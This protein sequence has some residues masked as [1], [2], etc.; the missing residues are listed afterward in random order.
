MAAVSSASGLLSLLSEPSDTLRS[1]ALQN[2]DRVVHE[3]WFQISASIASVEALYEDEEFGQRELAA[4]VASKVFYHLGELDD[5]LAYA[6]G[7]GKLFDVNEQSEYVQTL[8]ARCLD[9]Y[10]ELRLKQVEAKQDVQI[11]PRL[12]SIVERMLERCCVHGQ[13]EQAVGVALEARRLDKLEEIIQ[14]STDGLRTL[15]YALRCCQGLIINRDF[16]QQVLRLLI[17]LYEASRSPDYVDICQCLMFLDDAPEV[18]KILHSLLTGTEDDE[19]LA[20]QTC[21]DL[22]ENEMQSF[23][24][25]VGQKCRQNL[26]QTQGSPAAPA[27]EEG[28][29]AAAMDTDAPAPAS[30]EPAQP[31]ADA[32]VP[33]HVARHAS[34]LSKVKN[35]L[36]GQTPIGMHLDFLHNHADLQILKNIK[37]AIDSRNSVAHSATVFA[38]A[39][40]HSGTTVD[41]F[42][43]ENMDWLS[44]ATNW[45]KFSATAGLGVIHRWLAGLGT[46]DDEMFE[47]VKNIL[48]TDSAVAGEAAGISMG[49]IMAGT[50]TDKATEMLAYAHDTQHEKIIRGIVL[51]LALVMYGR[52]EG[53]ETLVEQM[54]R[55]QDPIIRYGAMYVLGMAYRGTSNNGAVQ[56][57]LHFAVSDV[58]DDVRRAAVLCLGF[59]LMNA[60][61]QCPRIVALLS[62][63]F[64]PHVRY[65]AAMA[66]GMAC[67]GTGLKDAVALLE[68]LLL[69]GVDFVRQG[70]YIA[71]ALVMVQQPEVR[72]AS[73]RKRLDK[74]I[75]NKHEEIMAKL[76]AIMAAGIL[77]AGGRNVGIGLRSR[78]GFFRRTSVIGLA[79]FTQYWCV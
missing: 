44:R 77:D 3:F 55:D 23:L 58:S 29:G 64:N 14:R 56:K 69:D 25:K 2:L 33:E 34:K 70:A 79:V 42:L 62:E 60:P 1:Y 53:A 41:M 67:A 47:D 30:S 17:R 22:V 73:F 15:K 48:Y 49:L 63:S 16:R 45:A 5:A 13:F 38:N 12:V 75:G 28:G 68:P 43:R 57:L 6:L 26:I 54:S 35:I 7:A 4:I 10:F 27:A 9:Q 31:Q 76:G 52:E 59:V 46:N 8:I 74:S 61:Q 40:M 50:A 78:S 19:L 24:T 20:Y 65:G 71:T 72:L 66:V 11:D 21:F 39:I 32:P 36:S 37:G 51:G 18:A